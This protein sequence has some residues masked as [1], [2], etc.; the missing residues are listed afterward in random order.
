MVE[1]LMEVLPNHFI[2]SVDKTDGS[3]GDWYGWNGNRW[4]KSDAPLRRAIMYE[5]ERYWKSIMEKWDIEYE[6]KVFEDI[7]EPDYNYRLWKDTKWQ[8][9]IYIED[10]K[11]YQ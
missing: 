7:E 5:I 3:R 6:G 4:G 10:V 8:K 2:Y 1:T 11:W 9:N